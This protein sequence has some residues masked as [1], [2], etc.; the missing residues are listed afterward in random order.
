M[1]NV[2]SRRRKQARV[3]RSQPTITNT[4]DTTLQALQS[5]DRLDALNIII[6]SIKYE[7]DIADLLPEPGYFKSQFKD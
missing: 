5:M 2:L 4:G 3:V 7:Q 6:D 1:L